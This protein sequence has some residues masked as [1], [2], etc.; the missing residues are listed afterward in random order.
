MID[1]NANGSIDYEELIRFYATNKRNHWPVHLIFY[2]QTR[3][4]LVLDIDAE[5][6]L[7]QR[8]YKSSQVL[9]KKKFVGFAKNIF[10]LDDYLVAEQLF[11]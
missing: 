5:E 6:F 9:K 7:I 10:Y 11:S 8:G 4:L 2:I 3:I 1:T